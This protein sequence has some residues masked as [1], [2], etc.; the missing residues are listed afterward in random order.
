MMSW[1]ADVCSSHLPPRCWS[2]QGSHLC[3]YA[4]L[5]SSSPA[6]VRSDAAGDPRPAGEISAPRPSVRLRTFGYTSPVRSHAG[7]RKHESQAPAVAAA[8]SSLPS[9]IFAVRRNMVDVTPTCVSR[10][11]RRGLG[12]HGHHLS[13]I[14]GRKRLEEHLAA[15][16]LTPRLLA[17]K[18]RAFDAAH[19]TRSPQDRKSV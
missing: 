2:V 7:Q 15:V 5:R 11:S 9:S 17:P 14:T 1:S 16:P 19:D 8:K 3:S 13:E 10:Y 4:P 6:V 12:R 18:G